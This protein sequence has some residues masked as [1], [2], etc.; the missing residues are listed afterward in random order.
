MLKRPVFSSF[1]EYWH[2]ARYLSREQ[3]KIIFKSLSIDQKE[4]LDDSYLKEGWSDLFYRNEIDDKIDKLKEDYGFDLM[5]IR[6]KALNGKSVYVSTEF[7][8]VVEEQM[9]KYK[10]ESVDFVMSGIKAIKCESNSKV[11][12]IVNSESNELD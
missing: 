10:P 2:Y 9:N 3:R 6:I 12:L 11:C 7:W 8:N 1:A 4:F 5:E